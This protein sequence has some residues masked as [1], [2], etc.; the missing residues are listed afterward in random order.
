MLFCG[1][2]VLSPL[3][4]RNAHTVTKNSFICVNQSGFAATENN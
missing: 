4:Q 1:L 2:R 3:R